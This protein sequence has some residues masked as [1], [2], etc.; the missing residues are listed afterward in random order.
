M[1]HLWC[2][3]HL[4]RV[5]PVQHIGH[6]TLQPQQSRSYFL[7][8]VSP[9]ST[10]RMSALWHTPAASICTNT[11][12][13]AAGSPWWWRSWNKSQYVI[14]SEAQ[15]SELH[16]SVLSPLPC[17]NEELL[18][19]LVLISVMTWSSPPFRVVLL[20]NHMSF[21]FTES[22]P[23]PGDWTCDVDTSL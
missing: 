10:D 19:W 20:S 1:F 7:I 22:A 4:Q 18:C 14:P 12:L 6:V 9:G 2:G 23:D 15:E 13:R 8:C 3:E 21:C 17:L 5:Q 11:Q 16:V